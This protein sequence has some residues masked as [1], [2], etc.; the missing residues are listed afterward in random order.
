MAMSSW[1]TTA[2]NNILANTGINMDEGM[3]PSAVNDSIREIMAVLKTAITSGALTITGLST[4]ANGTA[5]NPS[6]VFTG[7]T[8]TGFYKG[9][10][11]AIGASLNGSSVLVI[12]QTTFTIAGGLNFVTPGTV[13]FSS[14]GAATFVAGDKYLVVSASG[15]V[16]VSATGPAS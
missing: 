9:T 11:H 6:M 12:D 7:S 15:N 2:A 3:A 1:S 8:T 4:F 13:Q 5:A 16:H 10:G 14:M